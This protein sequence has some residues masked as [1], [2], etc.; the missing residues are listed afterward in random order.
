MLGGRAVGEGCGEGGSEMG[1]WRVRS[2]CGPPAASSSG[3]NG[4]AAGP[5]GSAAATFDCPAVASGAGGSAVPGARRGLRTAGV[6][7]VTGGSGGA[8]AAAAAGGSCARRSVGAAAVLSDHTSPGGDA[9]V[10]HVRESSADRALA[11]MAGVAAAPG[12]RTSSGRA[13]GALLVWRLRGGSD[14][15]LGFRTGVGTPAAVLPGSQAAGEDRR[16]DRVRHGVQP[17]QGHAGQGE[18]RLG[19]HPMHLV[20]P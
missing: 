16:G 2:P 17:R 20:R 7:A 1:W 5:A 10:V 18:G 15:T 3:T 19:G 11:V 13:A 8:A 12:F 9:K 6:C 14:L 4:R